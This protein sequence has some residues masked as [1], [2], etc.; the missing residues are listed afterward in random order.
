MILKR[1]RIFPENKIGRSLTG[2]GDVFD[3]RRKLSRQENLNRTFFPDQPVFFGSTC[4]FVTTRDDSQLSSLKRKFVRCLFFEEK[5][6]NHFSGRSHISAFLEENAE[7]EHRS[8]FKNKK[9][10]YSLIY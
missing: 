1:N 10:M 2:T 3:F 9:I 5:I 4:S 7:L 6:R 8:A